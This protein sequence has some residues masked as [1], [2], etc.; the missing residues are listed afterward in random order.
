MAHDHLVC[1][2]CGRSEDIATVPSTCLACGGILDL[3]LGSDAPSRLAGAGIWAW[4]ARLPAVR[5]E[6]RIT[7]GEGATPLLRANRLG[8]AKGLSNFWVKNDSLMPTGSF[9]D[10]AIAVATSLACEYDRPGMV[11]SSSGN[12]GASG[13]AYAAR[14]GRPIVI[15]VPRTA[16]E[17]KLRQ[18]AVTGAQLVTVD[19]PTS[20]CCRLAEEMARAKGWVNLTTTFHNPFGVDGYATI[21]FE[22]APFRP[23]VLLLPISSGPLLVGLMKGFEHLQ[24]TGVI[25]HV[26]RPIAVQPEAC[27]HIARAYSEGG[28]VRPWT[29]Q[30]TVA[31]ALNDTLEGYEN[32]GDYTLAKIRQ[33]GGAAIAISEAQ[34]LDGRQEL[35]SK[36]GIVLEP[37]A[38]ISVGAIEPLLAAGLIQQHERVVAVAT[39]H[40][41]KDLSSVEV[42]KGSGS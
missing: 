23:D 22:L 32:N 20:E 26:P 5:A 31:S 40:G 7:L 14:A 9:K 11:L 6:N 12:A 34:I 36:E 16:P 13:A 4:A 30:H 18:I 21:A 28:V 25:N 10:R 24:A 8:Q 39:G 33:H 42:A 1:I 15:L 38:A 29:H 35:A 2:A 41:L 3:V 19:G 27:A 17:A 37:S